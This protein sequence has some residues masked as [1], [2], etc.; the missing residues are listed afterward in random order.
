MMPEPMRLPSLMAFRA[1][2][3]QTLRGKPLRPIDMDEGSSTWHLGL[4][5]APNRVMQRLAAI[6]FTDVDTLPDPA[7]PNGTYYWVT[8]RKSATDGGNK[9][10]LREP[11][12]PVSG[13][14]RRG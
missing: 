3:L 11:V 4:A 6:G 5:I 8:G 10:P 2:T 13:G 14:S 1:L 7:Y 12:S 9:V